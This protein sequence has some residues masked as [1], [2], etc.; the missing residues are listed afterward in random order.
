MHPLLPD[1]YAVLLPA[2]SSLTLEPEIV[3]FLQQGGAS[4]LLG[5]THGE[6]ASRVMSP[7]R[8]NSET[9][10]TFRHL[11]ASARRHARGDLLIA[12]DQEMSGIQRLHRLVPPLP[13]L[14]E[15][16]SLSSLE[17][18][19]RAAA[20]A[21]EAKKLGVN[22]FLSPVADVV[23]GCNPWL[24]GRNLGDDAEEVSRIACAFTQGVQQSGVLATGKHF[25][26]HPVIP[27][28]PAT[29]EAIAEAS[30]AELAPSRSVFKALI[31][32]GIEAIM[33]GP[34][35]VPAVDPA[36]PS[37]TSMTT[38]DLL[39][40][41]LGFKGLIISDD[42]ESLGLLRG[43]DSATVAI[44]ALKAGAELLLISNPAKVRHL[45][46]A[47]VNAALEGELSPQKLSAAAS[48]V[49]MLATRIQQSVG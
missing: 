34:A 38:M 11:I 21:T 42:L 37:S 23:T 46:E 2:F 8:Q 36:E 4:L 25:P 35:L 31:A 18:C 3:Q 14:A 28:D 7:E 5:E 49:R 16:R 12:V 32:A 44:A 20:T 33:T 27:L 13:S 10:D 15:A 48:K 17:V 26:G 9:A 40:Q 39:R 1:A 29:E 47:I 45:A 24:A 41:D 22:L 43:R 19:Q 30:F 6:Y